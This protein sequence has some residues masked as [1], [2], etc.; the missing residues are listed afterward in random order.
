MIIH[1]VKSGDT[2]YNIAKFYG[3]TVEKLVED[4]QISMPDRLTVG[5]NIVID[6][7]E[8]NYVVKRGDTLFNISKMFD[9]PLQD[10][11][12]YNPQLSNPNLINV[13]QVV[14]IPMPLKEGTIE[15]NGYAI[16]N[17]NTETL[18]KTLPFLTYLSIFSYQAKEDGSMYTLYEED[19]IERA[20]AQNVAPNM[21][22]TNIGGSGGFSSDIAHSILTSEPAQTNLINNILNTLNT[23]NYSGVDIDFEYIYPYDKDSYVQF[24]RRLNIELKKQ[25]Y[26]LSVAVAP[27]YRANQ[28][29]I[30][31]EAHDY[32][33]IGEIADR[34]IIMTYEWGYM[35]GPPM[36][37]SPYDQ[38]R[39]VLKYAVTE[40]PSNKILMGMPNYAY[41]WTIPFTT[42]NPATI[43]SNVQAVNLAIEKGSII[44]FDNVAKAPYFNY[45]DNL[46]NKHVVWFD[47]AESTYSRLGLVEEFNLAGVSYW[48]INNFFNQ[49]W[50]VL[51]G[52]Y[53][54]TKVI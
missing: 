20:R 19:L 8:I 32:K 29:G 9:I 2:L 26:T 46:G 50:L 28:S 43:L 51:N 6:T 38:V 44:N 47:N 41:D 1:I 33:R 11:I 49:N 39:Q 35:Y 17:I 18:N 13:G 40:I 53:N 36:A 7:T 4:N 24:L 34:V 42:N 30:L 14:K 48:T 23:K 10:I 25:N 27:K 12:N 37:I 52:L 31:Y 3:V 22:V 21:V 54:V 45:F 16:A 5:Q 15:V